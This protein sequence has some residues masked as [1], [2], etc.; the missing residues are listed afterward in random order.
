M[1]AMMAPGVIQKALVEEGFQI[2]ADE[3]EQLSPA[4][5]AR[6]QQWLEGDRVFPRFI[7]PFYRDETISVTAFTDSEDWTLQSLG[8]EIADTLTLLGIS[9][10]SPDAAVD[11]IS[12]YTPAE[13]D[14]AG[15]WTLSVRLEST[16]AAE[17]SRDVEFVACPA[18]V[19]RL[20]APAAP[21]APTDGDED[22]RPIAAAEAAGE[23]PQ[24]I[25]AAPGQAETREQAISRLQSGLHEVRGRY[26]D[27]RSHYEDLAEQAKNAKKSME[28]AQETLNDLIGELDDAIN[29][30]AWQTRLPLK[31]DDGTTTVEISASPATVADPAKNASVQQLV[32]HGVSQKQVEKLIE[33]DVET[34]AELEKRIRDIIG[35]YKKIKGIGESAADKVADALIAWRKDN[36]YGEVPEGGE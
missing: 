24:P 2:T 15:A 19:D 32:E 4:L 30:E 12:Q 5:Q 36:G 1:S 20:I 3:I 33:A 7:V 16:R 23:I 13:I 27:R 31:Y 8:E 18:C 9:V 26:L 21:A 34:I 10:A 6:L 29:S 28:S 11:L 22:D 17:E 25:P 14:E 35:W